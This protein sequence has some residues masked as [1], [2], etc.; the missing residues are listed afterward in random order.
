VTGSWTQSN[1]ILDGATT[2]TV[3]GLF[4]WSGGRQSGPGSTV[5]NGGMVSS[6]AVRYLR[7]R[8][9][10][11]N[12]A[13]T[14]GGTGAQS[15]WDGATLNNNAPLV[16]QSDVDLPHYTGT[17]STFNN[18]STL[19]KSGGS[20][21]SSIGADFKNNGGSVSVSSGAFAFTKTFLQT[22][23]GVLDIHILGEFDFDVFAVTQS[24]TLGGTANIIR[25]GYAPPST[26]AFDIMTCNT[27]GGAFTTVNGN[28]VSFTQTVDTDKVTLTA[29]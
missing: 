11:L 15:F 21:L 22:S 5:A 19:T 2:V 28:G 20:D 14:I 6:G 4:T 12:A 23:S 25:N 13:S 26:T 24:A 29:D 17:V 27:C 3:A 18:F 9:L 8:T 7:A 10:T 1:G 16:I